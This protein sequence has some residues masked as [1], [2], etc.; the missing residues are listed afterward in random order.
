MKKKCTKCGEVKSID[1][2]HKSNI[3]KDSHKYECAICSNEYRRKHRAN[4]KEKYREYERKNRSKE[5]GFLKKQFSNIL[6]RAKIKKDEKHQCHFT[7]EEFDNAF[8]KHKERHGMKSAWG[9]PHL[10][11]TTIHQLNEGLGKGCK[12]RGL[13]Q[14]HCKSN[15][16]ADRLDSSK[17]YTIQNLIFIRA[18]EN[19]R[20]KDTTY[21]DCKIQMRLHEERF[22]N[23][24]SI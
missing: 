10:E 11:I 18:D 22:I 3:Y 7:Y 21:E 5:R 12:N 4:N 16:S 20:K 15:L 23:M 13:T 8:Q 2:F 17:P 6:R 9:P 24:E 1:D 19:N 14:I